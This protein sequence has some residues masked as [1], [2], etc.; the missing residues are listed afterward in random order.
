MDNEKNKK[1]LTLYY[2]LL[3]TIICIIGVSF[4]WFRLYLSQSEN[5]AI[6]TRNCFDTTL[7]EENSQ[8]ELTDAFPISD[9]D[10]L[11]QTPFTFTLKNNCSSYVKA[12]IT[13]YSTNRTSTD[14]SYLKDDY[15][16]VNI[17]PKGTTKNSSLILGEQS[18]TNL[19]ADKEG[20]MIID[21]GLNANEEKSYDLRIWMDSETSLEQGLS[22]NWAGK[23]VV[24]T[25]ASH[26]PSAPKGWYES[27]DGALLAALKRDNEITSPLTIPGKEVSAHTLDEINY[28]SSILYAASDKGA[29][30]YI[31]YGTGWESNGTGFNLIGT[32][33]T[34]D[35]FIN[36]YSELIGKYITSGMLESA[37]SE[38]AGEMVETTNLQQVY[39]VV[40]ATKNTLEYKTLS[41][42]KNFKE[43]VVSSTEDDYGTSYY[44]R[45]AVK[46][47]YVEF[48]NKCWRIVRINGD[49]TIKL[50]LHNNNTEE[51][52]NP[53]AFSVYNSNAAIIE[54]GKFNTETNDN[55]YVGFMYGT[56]GSNDYSSTH[57]NTNKSTILTNLETWYKNNLISYENKIADTIW[58]SDK[59]N[60]ANTNFDPWGENPNGLGY[61]QNV[62]YYSSVQRL[63]DNNN[64]AGGTG[65]SLKCSG[66]LSKITGKIGLLT[67][68]EIVFTGYNATHVNPSAYLQENLYDG[69]WTITPSDFDDGKA[70]VWAVFGS[71][72][73]LGPRDVNFSIEH[74]IRPAIA[75]TS[76]TTISGG[77]GTSEDPYII[78]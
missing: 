5:N 2:S 17:S 62:T 40:N 14:A 30:Y 38:T 27:E 45:G 64:H 31:T 11:K 18:L 42:N 34:S 68:D 23:I 74:G 70:Y 75:L 13:I 78:Q 48:A 44:F 8:I 39:Y 51:Q 76:S 73:S 24:I 7:T 71:G 37:G 16:K 33:I 35:I 47:N 77:T 54:T 10:G 52:A 15:L 32:T 9:E 12:Y 69:W 3:V 55:A 29:N 43:A 46:N 67:V 63:L 41:S 1:R 36:S 19:E 66:E 61:A 56:A 58:C 50:V 53:C 21:T 4:A 60:I 49:G 28:A 59:N 26:L 20:Y 25:E 72:G 6:S 57:E 65:P 22:K